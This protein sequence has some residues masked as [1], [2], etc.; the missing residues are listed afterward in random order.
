MKVPLVVRWLSGSFSFAKASS[1]FKSKRCL[2]FSDTRNGSP[3]DIAT[4][5]YILSL[6]QA[7]VLSILLISLYGNKIVFLKIRDHSNSIK[8][9]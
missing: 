8:I 9:K 4:Y 6:L 3:Q 2:Q 1:V 5:G 7:N